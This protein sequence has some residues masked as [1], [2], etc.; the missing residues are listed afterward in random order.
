MQEWLMQPNIPLTPSLLHPNLYNPIKERMSHHPTY[1]IDEVLAEQGHSVL[2]LPPHHLNLNPKQLILATIIDWVALKNTTPKMDDVTH[3]TKE[4]TASV[5]LE[6]W[7]SRCHHVVKA[8][9]KYFESE[10]LERF[11]VNPNN[12]SDA[13]DTDKD[14]NTGSLSET[15][16]AV[17]DKEDDDDDV[18]QDI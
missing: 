12:S 2:H 15:L 11:T 14:T 13:I 3:L 17:I 18:H 8:A 16:P 4:R 9:A 7:S 5:T 10:Q 1:H 6:N